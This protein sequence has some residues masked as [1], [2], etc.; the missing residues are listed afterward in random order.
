MACAREDARIIVTDIDRSALEPP[1]Q[2]GL[3]ARVLDMRNIAGRAASARRPVQLRRPRAS[4]QQL[5]PGRSEDSC[6]PPRGAGAVL[7]DRGRI[8]KRARLRGVTIQT[9]D[10]EAR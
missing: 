2:A 10:D 6:S 8:C 7:G 1:A 9:R 5:S 4:L 3:D